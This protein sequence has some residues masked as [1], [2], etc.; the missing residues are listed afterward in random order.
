MSYIL[1]KDLGGKD[2]GLK[3]NMGAVDVYWQNLN[4]AAFAAASIY[5]SFY[6]GLV[7]NDMVKG[8][9]SDYTLEEVSEWVDKMYEAGRQDEIKQVCD[10]FANTRAYAD[11][12]EKIK[13]KLS[14]M[15]NEGKEVDEGE[16]KKS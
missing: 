10:L 3:F 6:A 16:E 5:V 9:E 11:R 8:I 15:A 13:E 12:L 4:F 7:G 1:V 2:R 14:E